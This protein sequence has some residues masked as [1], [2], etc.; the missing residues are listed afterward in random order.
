M[1]WNHSHS[2]LLHI[3][4]VEVAIA[5][6]HPVIHVSHEDTKVAYLI[7]LKTRKSALHVLKLELTDQVTCHLVSLDESV[8]A[9]TKMCRNDI[10]MPVL[11]AKIVCE[12][13]FISNHAAHGT[14]ADDLSV[15][16]SYLREE[17]SFDEAKEEHL[18]HV[19]E[20]A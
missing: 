7:T 16:I 11:D 5:C 9:M 13:T 3:I 4:I 1:C 15:Y 18:P 8:L 17:L 12:T 2:V 14:F 20:L 6:V 10:E 19:Q